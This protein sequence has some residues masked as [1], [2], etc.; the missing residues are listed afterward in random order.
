[1][2]TSLFI[3]IAVTGR[4]GGAHFNMGVTVAVYIVEYEHWKKNLPIAITVIIAD[5]LG[6]YTGIGIACGL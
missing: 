4:V 2:V 3:A 6:A 5:L 1:V